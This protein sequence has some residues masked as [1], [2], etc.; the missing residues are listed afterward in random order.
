MF[1]EFVLPRVREQCEYLDYSL[2]HVDGPQALRTIDPL[3]E[4]ESLTALQFTP[5]PQVPQGGNPCWYD[6]YK[7]I[8]AAGKSVMAVWIEPEQIKPLLD[9]V[10]PEG[11][12]LMINLV[13]E[14]QIEETA[15][16]LD[17]YR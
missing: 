14:R 2:Y 6:L 10:G 13:E 4:I 3:L 16:I 7:K 1:K 8:K 15:L 5:G 11:M 12:Y 17:Q 9:A